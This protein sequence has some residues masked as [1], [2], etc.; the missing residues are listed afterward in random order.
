MS[1]STSDRSSTITI[2]NALSAPLFLDSST[3]VKQGAWASGSNPP[4]EIAAGTTSA[5]I[6]AQPA[7][8]DPDTEAIVAYRVGSTT[9]SLLTVRWKCADSNGIGCQ[10]DPPYA[11]P[12]TA[13]AGG[14]NAERNQ[15]PDGD[16]LAI[17][18][19]V[20]SR[21]AG[22]TASISQSFPVLGLDGQTPVG[23]VWAPNDG[24]PGGA[25]V[26]NPALFTGPPTALYVFDVEVVNDIQVTGSFKLFGRDSS[27]DNSFSFGSNGSVKVDAD[28]DTTS[29]PIYVQSWSSN[30]PIAGGSVNVSWDF[31]DKNPIL[32]MPLEAYWIFGPPM[33]MWSPQPPPPGTPSLPTGVWLQTLR[34]LFS[35]VMTPLVGAMSFL[36]FSSDAERL[37]FAMDMTVQ[38]VVNNCMNGFDGKYTKTYRQGTAWITQIYGGTA[39]ALWNYCNNLQPNNLPPP[40][41]VASSTAMCADQKYLV[42]VMLGALG[43]AAGAASFHMGVSIPLGQMMQSGVQELPGVAIDPSDPNRFDDHLTATYIAKGNTILDACFGPATGSQSADQYI[44]ETFNASA[45]VTLGSITT[46]AAGPTGVCCVNWLNQ[47][48]TV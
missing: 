28:N 15:I 26:S 30:C 41:T 45:Q 44:A 6:E 14:G 3:R 16:A 13:S 8:K 27:G 42:Q 20:C 1:Q 12:F 31:G 34:D 5:A 38:I 24:T 11:L 46:T 43:V 23:P 33:A 47:V 40:K 21:I 18:F 22:V 39:F 7:G 36:K 48:T 10:S 37:A 19:T 32:L 9:G 29:A 25:P 2:V 17:T 35:A 4:G